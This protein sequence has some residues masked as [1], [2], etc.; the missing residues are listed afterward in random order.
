MDE[1]VV[2]GQQKRWEHCSVMW[3]LGASQRKKPMSWDVSLIHSLKGRESLAKSFKQEDLFRCIT[4]TVP[5]Y[6]WT[7][8]CGGWNAEQEK[9]NYRLD[10]RESLELCPEGCG[11]W[12]YDLD[13]WPFF[14]FWTG[15]HRTSSGWTH[16]KGQASPKLIKIRQPLPP[17]DWN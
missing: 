5:Q 8:K 13:G 10:W 17:M 6:Q 15:Y 14:D 9:E 3:S 1:W 4:Q 7:V 2:V 11:V 12:C 16:Y